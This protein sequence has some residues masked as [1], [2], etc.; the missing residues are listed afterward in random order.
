MGQMDNIDRIFAESFASWNIQ[1]PLDATTL[2][3]P[4]RINKAGWSISYVFGED[5]LDYYAEHRMT[6]PRHVR[7][8]ADGRV[9]GLEAPRDGYVIPG[10]ADEATER[11]AREDYYAYNRRVHAELRAKG[12]VDC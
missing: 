3:R 8:Y 5:Y 7:I 6:N 1:L 12:L 11:Q 2:R 9:E 10:D 4:G